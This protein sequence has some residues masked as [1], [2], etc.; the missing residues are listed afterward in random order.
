MDEPLVD[1]DPMAFYA[2]QHDMRAEVSAF[3]ARGIDVEDACRIVGYLRHM[4]FGCVSGSETIKFLSTPE[5]IVV[6]AVEIREG[7]VGG[8]SNLL[9]SQ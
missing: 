7:R 5:E 9:G 1:L 6:M 3:V 8:D 2:S 4:F